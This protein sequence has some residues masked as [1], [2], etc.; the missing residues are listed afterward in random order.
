MRA[1]RRGIRPLRAVTMLV[2]TG[3]I[4]IGLAMHDTLRHNRRATDAPT[5]SR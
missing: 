5:G 1:A 3:I 2:I 4:F